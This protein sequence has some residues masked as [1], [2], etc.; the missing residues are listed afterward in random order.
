MLVNYT[1]NGGGT[2][3]AARAIMRDYRPPKKDKPKPEAT[4]VAPEAP[5]PATEVVAPGQADIDPLAGNTEPPP[6]GKDAGETVTAHEPP[7][8]TTVRPPEPRATPERVK[9]A[10]KKVDLNSVFDE[11]YS[12][13]SALEKHIRKLGPQAETAIIDGYKR[14]AALDII[15]LIQKRFGD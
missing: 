9:I 5:D 12:Y 6:E 4:G 11:V 3:A 14:E 15:G 13:M 2:V 10:H 7:A 1:I 8:Q